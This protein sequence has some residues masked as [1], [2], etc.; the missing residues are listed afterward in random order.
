MEENLHI[1]LV[2]DNPAEAF[3]FQES[4]ARVQNPPTV[5]HAERLDQALEYLKENSI[6]AILLDLALPDSEGLSTLER[7]NA[8][9][10]HLPIIVLT[11][12]EDEAVAIEAVRKGAQDYLLKGQTG[13]RQLVQTVHHAVERKRLERAVAQSAQRHLLLAEVSAAVVGQRDMKGLLEKVAD[14]ACKLTSTRMCC[15]GTGYVEGKLHIRA[16]SRAG[17]S[18]PRK[19]RT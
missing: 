18:L 7:A 6:D 2:E 19:L 11:G 8:A 3:L 12:L 9:A 17:E 10:E 1:L 16:L 15:T 5:I 13:A 14:A 4:V